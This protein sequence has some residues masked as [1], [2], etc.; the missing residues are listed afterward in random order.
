MDNR[1]EIKDFLTTRRAR[2]SPDSAG[3]TWRGARRVPGLRRE[4]VAQLAGVSADYYTQIER[5]QVTG[6]SDEILRAIGRGLR[7][8]DDETRH[9]FSLVRSVQR[10]S[11]AKGRSPAT[12]P[13]VPPTVRAMLAAM[14]GLPA[15]IQ[16][17]CLDV[18]DA[19]ALGRALYTDLFASDSSTRSNLAEFIFLDPRAAHFF[20]DWEE[21]ADD[22]VGMLRLAAARAPHS[23]RTAAVIDRLSAH[24]EAFRARWSRHDVVGRIHGSMAFDHPAVGRFDLDYETLRIASAPGI[25]LVGYSTPADVADT[26]PLQLLSTWCTTNAD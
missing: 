20:V 21:S 7:L 15:L 3:I 9:L 8:D 11:T 23:R 19:N 6:V 13:T 14:S 22:A 12:P 16:T 17:T 4:E 18:V 2:I 24:S 5:G 10:R 25:Y 26:D 1:Q